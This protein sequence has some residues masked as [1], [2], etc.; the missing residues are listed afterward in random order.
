MLDPGRNAEVV[1]GIDDDSLAA[2]ESFYQGIVD[3]TVPVSSPCVAELAKLIENTFWH[4]NIAPANELAMFGHEL[5]VERWEAINAASTKPFGFMPFTPGPGVRGHS[6][7]IDPSYP[8]WRVQRTLGRGFRFVEPAERHQ[9]PHAGLRRPPAAPSPEQARTAHDRVPDTPIGAR[10]QEEHRRR[11]QFTR[12]PR[13]RT[14]AANGRGGP[15]RRPAGDRAEPTVISRAVARVDVTPEEFAAADAV[16]L[17]TDRDAF[18]AADVA[19][20]A[21]HILDCRWVLSGP[22]VEAL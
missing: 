14:A 13:R 22:N 17:L 4:V 21:R 8:S 2:V 7:P 6:L 16:V 12:H 11:A 18:T 5:G 1:S 9:Q 19:R 20:H 10:L 3:R 15:G